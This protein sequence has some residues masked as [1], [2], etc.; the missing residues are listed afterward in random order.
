M[1]IAAGPTA[2]VFTFGVTNAY[3]CGNVPGATLNQITDPDFPGATS[4]CYVDGYFAFSATGDTAEWFISKLLDPTA[5]FDALDFV[6]SDAMPNVIRRVV[7]H[8]EQLWTIGEGGFEV[9]YNAGSSGLETAPGG[10]SFFPFRRMAGGMSCRSGTASP[11][12]V[13]R[14]G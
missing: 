8:R 10:M 9:W 14:G 3:T 13:C 7:S 11:Q 2:V 12:S 1:T 4:V 5:S 6:F